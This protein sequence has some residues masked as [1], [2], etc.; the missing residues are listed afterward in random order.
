LQERER[1]RTAS[2]RWAVGRKEAASSCLYRHFPKMRGRGM[3][4]DM[5]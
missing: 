2:S 3:E 4:V 5:D 1:E